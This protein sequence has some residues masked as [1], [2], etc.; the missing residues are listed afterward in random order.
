MVTLSLLEITRLQYIIKSGI[1]RLKLNIYFKNHLIRN[2]H[3][4]ISV[5]NSVAQILYSDSEKLCNKPF[6][7]PKQAIAQ[8]N[9]FYVT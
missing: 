3:L 7:S 9:P 6:T 1:E 8:S 4:F 2:A 5:S